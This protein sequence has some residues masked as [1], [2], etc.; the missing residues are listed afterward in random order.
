VDAATFAVSALLLSRISLVEGARRAISWRSLVADAAE[1]FRAIRETAVLRQNTVLSLLAQLSL[2]VLNGLSPVLVF[3]EYG[4]G[5]GQYGATEGAIALGA[6][7]TSVMAPAAGEIGKGRSILAGFVGFG[8]VLL[9]FA[10]SPPFGVALLLFFF[11]GVTNVL[12]YVPNMTLIQEHAPT[13]L[14]G[15]VFGV[16][17][18]LLNLTW[19]PV[20]L[21]TGSLAETLPVHFLIGAAGAFTILVAVVGSAFRSI[22]DVA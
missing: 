12:F 1:G 14:R 7:A 21:A 11:V 22:R 17:L 9:A 2:P 15:R 19:L 8:L 20:I 10:A 5:P 18:A 13:A 16:R 4:L 6:V 3:R